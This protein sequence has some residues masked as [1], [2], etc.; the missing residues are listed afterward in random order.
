M[1]GSGSQQR[2]LISAEGRL[3]ELGSNFRPRQPHSGPMCPRF[4]PEISCFSAV[5]F[6]R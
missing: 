3:R 5:C 6:Q 2:T 4:K 1:S